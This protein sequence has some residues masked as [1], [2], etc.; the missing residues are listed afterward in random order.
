MS[1][2]HAKDEGDNVYRPIIHLHIF[3]QAVLLLGCSPGVLREEL[4][5][6]ADF[7][8]HGLTYQV[9]GSKEEVRQATINFLTDKSI[10]FR[11]EIQE[12]NTYVISAHLSEPQQNEDR[13]IRRVAYRVSLREDAQNSPC[14]HAS[15]TWI[16]ESKGVRESTWRTVESDAGFSP[17]TLE[18]VKGIFSGRRC[19]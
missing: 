3:V 8:N 9:R 5:D 18:E 2:R 17:S 11:Q 12:P 14:S 1:V 6:A 4:P 19:Q 13:R 10:P 15:V 16:I 7:P